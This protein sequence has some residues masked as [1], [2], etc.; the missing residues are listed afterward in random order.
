MDQKQKNVGSG[1]HVTENEKVWILLIENSSMQ[2]LYWSVYVIIEGNT[3]HVPEED[4][5]ICVKNE[6]D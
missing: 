3:S 4:N 2:I 1:S 5:V 6:C